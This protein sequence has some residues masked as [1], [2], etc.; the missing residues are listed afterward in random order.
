MIPLALMLLSGT[1]TKIGNTRIKFSV[2]KTLNKLIFFYFACIRFCYEKVGT[3][4]TRTTT[5]TLETKKTRENGKAKKELLLIVFVLYIYQ[6]LKRR[7]LLCV[8]CGECINGSRFLYF[9][10]RD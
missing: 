3:I 2:R 10:K 5:C 1:E 7:D 8:D 4:I 6:G 9:D